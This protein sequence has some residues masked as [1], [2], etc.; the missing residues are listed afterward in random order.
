MLWFNAAMMRSLDPG[1]QIAE[2]EVDHRQM[3][4]C[5]VRVPIES[6]CLMAISHLGKSWITNPSVGADDGIWRNVLFDEVG[7]HFGAPI[8]HNAKPQ[9]PSVDIPRAHLA[10]I[11]ARTDFD[12]ADHSGLVMRAAPFSTRLAPNIAFVYFYRIVASDGVPLGTNHA[13]AEF[14][15]NLKGRLIAAESKL[16][17][18]LDGRL[19]RGLCRHEICAPKPSRKRRMA[20]LHDSASRKRCVGLASTA[21]QHYGRACLEP[22][23]FFDKPAF[24]ACKS[25]GPA[26]RLKI[27]GASRVIGKY[28][29]KFWKGS[30]EAAYVHV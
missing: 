22:I 15:E 12:G 9:A 14:V 23:G 21:A 28:P 27:A 13:N 29:L 17:L 19:A 5:L 11:L 20:R 24:R 7:K 30:R 2:N 8:G 6:Q 18:E 25:I 16:A 4:L 26:N 3:C 1:L 10:I